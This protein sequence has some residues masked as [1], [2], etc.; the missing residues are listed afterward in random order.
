MVSGKVES[1][2]SEF[3][4]EVERRHYISFIAHSI[5]HNST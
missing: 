2:S 1:V 5:L 4:A 3:F